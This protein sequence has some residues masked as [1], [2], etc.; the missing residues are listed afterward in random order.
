MDKRYAIVKNNIVENIVMWNGIT[1]FNPGEGATLVEIN[2]LP[3]TKIGYT[4]TNGYF[5]AP[6][7]QESNE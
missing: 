6:E 3:K 1:P 5:V 2:N 7:N 4:Y